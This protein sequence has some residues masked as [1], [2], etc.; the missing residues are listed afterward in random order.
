MQTQPHP[1]QTTARC[2]RLTAGV[3]IAGPFR[4]QRAIALDD[5]VYLPAGKAENFEEAKASFTRTFSDLLNGFTGTDRQ[6]GAA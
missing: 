4:G 2:G 1:V 3:F 5:G 6:G